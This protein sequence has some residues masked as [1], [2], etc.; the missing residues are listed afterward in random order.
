LRTND[1]E[2]YR[3]AVAAGVEDL[4]SDVQARVKDAIGR[5]A[6]AK[7]KAAIKAVKRADELG[8]A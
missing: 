2:A 7:D 6:D 1:Y 8:G 5:H 4:S 3:A